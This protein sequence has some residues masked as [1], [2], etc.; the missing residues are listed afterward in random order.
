[1][2]PPALTAK[3]NRCLPFYSPNRRQSRSNDRSPFK[4]DRLLAASFHGPVDPKPTCRQTQVDVSPNPSRRG[5]KPKSAPTFDQPSPLP[6]WPFQA[7]GRNTYDSSLFRIIQIPPHPQ[8]KP[9]PSKPKPSQAN[10]NKMAWICLFLFVRIGT[11]QWVTAIPNKN[12]FPSPFAL[13]PSAPRQ[14]R[15]R[16]LTS[17]TI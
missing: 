1:R 4:S 14:A 15:H 17:A 9:G 6:F 7:L 10:P 8:P 16:F 11:Y 3:E 13:S 2:R 5:A 12:F